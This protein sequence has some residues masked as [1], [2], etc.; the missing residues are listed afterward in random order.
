MLLT[1]VT[2]NV[3]VITVPEV[4][5]VTV[6]F[7]IIYKLPSITFLFNLVEL[8][9]ISKAT[10]AELKLRDILIYPIGIH[11]RP[12]MMIGRVEPPTGIK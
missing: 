7:K 11:C 8:T 2:L 6:F 10:T 3:T 5:L 4:T 12:L 9:S 1:P